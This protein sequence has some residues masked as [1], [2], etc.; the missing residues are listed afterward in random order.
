MNVLRM[1]SYLGYSEHIN[2]SHCTSIVYGTSFVQTSADQWVTSY[3]EPVCW[4]CHLFIICLQL[5][6]YP[7][8]RI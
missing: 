6:M 3:I 5:V 1:L 8:T 7:M 2:H 4:S